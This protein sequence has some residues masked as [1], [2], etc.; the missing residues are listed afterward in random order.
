MRLWIPPLQDARLA[1][2]DNINTPN[3]S[4]PVRNNPDGAD[5]SA[6]TGYRWAG[7]EPLRRRR[8]PSVIADHEMWSAIHFLLAPMQ[9]TLP[10]PHHGALQ[11]WQLIRIIVGIVQRTLNQV[12]VDF[13]S[14]TW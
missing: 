1:M 14:L 3:R 11:V 7:N 13:S 8:G 10:A 9:C 12:G 2:L 5:K 4:S 6:I